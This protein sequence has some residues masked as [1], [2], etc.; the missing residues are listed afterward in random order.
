MW[1]NSTNLVPADSHQ[2]A[3]TLPVS[4][5][6]FAA[7]LYPAFL[8]LMNTHF[9][10]VVTTTVGL[11]EFMIYLACLVVLMRP[12][13]VE[14][15]IIATLITAYLLL[16]TIFRGELELKGFRDVMIPILFYWLGRHIGDMAYADKTLKRLIWVVLAFG[17]FELFFLDWYSY[18][19]N[20]FS[21]YFSQGINTMSTN[22]VTGSSLNV[23]GLRP[24]GIGRTILPALL[25]SH[26]VS[27]IFLEP[28]SLG[29]FAV[30]VAAWGLAKARDEW[31]SALFFFATAVVMI[32]LSDSRYGIGAVSL[33][34]LIRGLPVR[35]L[36]FAV[37]LLPAVCMGGL[38]LIG[39]FYHG[40]YADNILGRLLVSGRA[41]LSFDV[42]MLFGFAPTTNFFYD[43]GYPYILTRV[44]LLLVVF[45]WFAIWM[46]KMQ[47][48]TGERFR[49]Y[50]ALYIALI[51]CIS[52][53]SLFALKSAGILWFLV[54][55]SA[56][57]ARGLAT[58]HW[59][60]GDDPRL[61]T[62]EMRYAN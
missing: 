37:S 3:S 50:I 51:L 22:F 11:T 20:I 27:S 8:C 5:I 34:L 19:F 28:V 17:F 7:I 61:S 54:G 45:L 58:T 9:F 41:L 48:E 52:G 32:T 23:N 44:G 46:I 25:G 13:R 47:D 60:K 35:A 26:R 49:V 42:P 18:F 10:R 53:T 16:L 59:S 6:L 40:Q 55:S 56:W 62:A 24:E 12:V 1:S 2:A 15:L 43:M 29:N 36:K 31:K 4:M 14:F 21:Y 57:R 38:V 39:L 30:I 33:M